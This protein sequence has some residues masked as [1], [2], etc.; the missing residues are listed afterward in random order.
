[1]MK[2]I[3]QEELSITESFEREMFFCLGCRACET[4]CPAGV[5]YGTLLSLSRTELFQA[6]EK[7]IFSLSAILLNSIFLSSRRFKFVAVAIRV[8]QKSGIVEALHRSGIIKMFSARLDEMLVL[9][10]KIADEFSDIILKRNEQK[11][12]LHT[13]ANDKRKPRAGV[14]LGCVTNVAFPEVN[15][16][17]VNVLRALG[18]DVVLPEF[19]SCCGALHHHQGD[20]VNAKQ[21]A[22]QVIK[23]FEK[24][25]CDVIVSNTAGCGATMKEY[26]ALFAGD[27]VN[28]ERV[29]IFCSKVR[30]ISEIVA[31]KQKENKEKQHFSDETVNVTYHDACHLAHGQK[32]TQEPRAVLQQFSNI[33][34]HEMKESTWCC[35]SAG[36]YNI[37]H[38]EDAQQLL[39]RKMERIAVT[40]ADIV[41]TGNVGCI[42]QLRYGAQKCNINVEVMHTVEFIEKMLVE[43]K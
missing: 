19:T 6:E 1:M 23:S 16:A 5:E 28:D 43:K 35:G 22:L 39:E 15:I 17:T 4:A 18:Y 34:L 26:G 40:N 30:D 29:R 41:I 8:L 13:D 20:V 31:E 10:P 36:V 37:T 7:K 27:K 21:L 12:T 24:I 25:S 32:I 11:T 42:Q 14:P 38:Y 2:G 33:T 3:A 9:A